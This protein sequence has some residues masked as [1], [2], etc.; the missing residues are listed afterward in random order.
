MGS[1]QRGLPLGG[2][3][4]ILLTGAAPWAANPACRLPVLLLPHLISLHKR[5][6]AG[7]AKKAVLD[8]WNEAAMEGSSVLL[9][10]PAYLLYTLQLAQVPTLAL[11]YNL[12]CE[13]LCTS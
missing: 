1:R 10:Q 12:G 6:K 5:R 8:L 3:K 13:E 4:N 7:L 11:E 2:P 9:P